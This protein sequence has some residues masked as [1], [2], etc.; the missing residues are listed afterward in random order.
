MIEIGVVIDGIS[1]LIKGKADGWLSDQISLYGQL[2]NYNTNKTSLF[3]NDPI[4]VKCYVSTSIRMVGCPHGSTRN[5]SVL[6]SDNLLF[7]AGGNSDKAIINIYN[8]NDSAYSDDVVPHSDFYAA[9]SNYNASLEVLSSFFKTTAGYAWI[10]VDKKTVQFT[11]DN[12]T[13]IT[14]IPLPSFPTSKRYYFCS[15]TQNGDSIVVTYVVS[16]FDFKS[17]DLVDVTYD[18]VGN[19]SSIGVEYSVPYML[20]QRSHPGVVS[21]ENVLIKQFG[22]YSLI[23]GSYG[24]KT[25]YFL[26]DI[27]SVDKYWYYIDPILFGVYSAG[28]NSF[29]AV[30]SFLDIKK[31]GNVFYFLF[32]NLD[33]GAVNFNYDNVVLYKMETV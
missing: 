7:W 12:F 25:G 28:V 14:T 24:Y 8:F 4:G 13:T 6:D 9:Y 33:D 20:K 16:S 3:P 23:Y 26:I 29:Y 2:N 22:D 1:K 30:K 32:A 31:I 21:R 10:H 27:T 11:N 15:A 18:T 17:Y 19:M 5:C